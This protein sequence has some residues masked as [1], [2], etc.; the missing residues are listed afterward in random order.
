M[1]AL[2][3]FDFA[4]AADRNASTCSGGMRR[5]LELA[6]GLIAAPEQRV[7]VALTEGAAQVARLIDSLELEGVRFGEVFVHR[8]TLDDVL[9]TLTGE[10]VATD[11]EETEASWA[12]AT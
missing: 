5:R 8:P 4:D 11:H 12:R 6:A 7:T 2:D 1:P 3:R 9:L 10:H